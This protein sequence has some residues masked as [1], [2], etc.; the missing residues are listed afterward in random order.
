MKDSDLYRAGN[1]LLV[2][3]CTALRR[4]DSAALGPLVTEHQQLCGTGTVRSGGTD[5]G[6]DSAA[7]RQ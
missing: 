5:Q 6:Y 1:F 3:A 2:G 7:N 4:E